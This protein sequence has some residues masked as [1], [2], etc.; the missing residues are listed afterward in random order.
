VEI[1]MLPFRPIFSLP[2]R[3]Q[4]KLKPFLGSSPYNSCFPPELIVLVLPAK[5]DFSSFP[6]KK[7]NFPVFP[8]KWTFV[9]FKYR[10][11]YFLEK[12]LFAKS[13]F[14]E[15]DLVLASILLK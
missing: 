1:D 11:E 15:A 6:A 12:I 8:P 10:R 5:T 7:R 9:F 4:R 3:L 2:G 14:H 13:W